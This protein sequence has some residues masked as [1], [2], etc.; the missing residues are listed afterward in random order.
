M[1]LNEMTLQ[2]VEARLQAVND[3]IEAATEV[4]AVNTLTEEKR[5]LVERQAE[6]K[7]LAQRKADAKLL[8]SRETSGNK[9]EENTKMEE[10]RTFALDSAEY[11]AAFLKNLQ[12]KDLDVRDEDI[13]GETGD[14]IADED[15][16]R[17]GGF[18]DVSDSAG[19]NE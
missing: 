15:D 7:D 2:D 16:V 14:Y 10:K 13:A 1:E 11:R 8:E 6:L 3:E 19:D 4:E 12:G 5:S 9:I 17:A 18:S